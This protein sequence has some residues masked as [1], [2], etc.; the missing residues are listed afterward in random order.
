MRILFVNG[1]PVWANGLPWGFRQLN[2]PIEIVT[3][4]EQKSLYQTMKRFQPELMLTVGWITEYTTSKLRLL[5]K[6]AQHFGCLQAYWAV[7]DINHL[8]KWSLPLVKKIDPN[9]VFTINAACISAYQECGI[10]AFHLDF[11]Y[12]PEFPDLSHQAPDDRFT[13]DVAL[14]ANCYPCLEAPH[15][16]RNRS[17]EILL[18]PLLEKEYDLLLC[19]RDWER[20]VVF[21]KYALTRVAYQG[22]ISF[23]DTFKVYKSA[24]II[25]NLQNQNVFPTQVTSRTFE[26]LGAG[27]FQLTTRTPAVEKL[28][29][30]RRH[31]VMSES[32]S[33]TLELVDYYLHNEQ[34]RREIA[35]NGQE[36][37]LA[38]HTYR[39]RAETFLACLK[40]AKIL[41]H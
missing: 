27:G 35:L 1:C 2:H 8:R 24:K 23:E 7:E 11:G 18:Y 41:K 26:I 13:H 5:K 31:L 9:V 29:A 34:E 38:Q 39:H 10:P 21:Q 32:P 12:N 40:K 6:A 17:L 25:L 4:I 36:E 37:V 14:I 16:F 19:G 3:Q 20:S 30:H 22:A 33:E 15:K 28:F